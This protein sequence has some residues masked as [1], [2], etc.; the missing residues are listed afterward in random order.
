VVKL[1]T[2]FITLNKARN[3][4]LTAYLQNVNGEFRD[5]PK[6]PAILVI[7]GG[8]Y[9]FCSDR[10]ADPVAFPYLEAGYQAF[11]LRY[12]VKSDAKWPNPLDDYEQAMRLIRS[13]AEEWHL[14]A[15]KVAVVGFSAGGHLSACAATISAE[16][17]NAAILGY[18]VTI[19]DGIMDN[20][21]D[22]PNAVEGV[23]ANTCP[24]FV[25]T[26]RTDGLVPVMNSIKFTEAL[27][28]H[29]VPFESHIYAFGPHGF[30]VCN[31]SVMGPDETYC[32]RM[33]GWVP[34]SVA[35]LKDVFGDFGSGAM[36]APANEAVKNFS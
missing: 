27:A 10:E 19:N 15:D 3:V 21:Y 33:P 6:R 17:P 30:S 4:T 36:G 31:S 23:D 11:V 14:Y 16:K 18:A 5:I 2:E 35:W 7:P 25:F 12:S 28:L 1:K 20:H 26:S 29:G 34:D 13:K 9:D 32:S 8:G 22:V 24:C